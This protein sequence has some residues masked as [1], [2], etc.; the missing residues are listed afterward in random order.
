VIAIPRDLN[1][2]PGNEH[3]KCGGVVG[4]RE[5]AAGYGSS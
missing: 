3:I 4:G 2:N 5:S 1:F